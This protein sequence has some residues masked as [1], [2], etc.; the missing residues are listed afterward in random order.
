MNWNFKFILLT[1][2][3]LTAIGASACIGEEKDG[4]QKEPVPE[5][6]PRSLLWV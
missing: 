1:C 5:K 4:L 2:I 6:T 3:L